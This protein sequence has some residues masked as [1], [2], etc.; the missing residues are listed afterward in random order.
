MTEQ[1][2]EPKLSDFST[3]TFKCWAIL[4]K[5]AY[6]LQMQNIGRIQ[7]IQK[8]QEKLSKNYPGRVI[9]VSSFKLSW[10]RSFK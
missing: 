5:E 3:C 8:K 9:W 6:I 7:L 2:F 10:N 1:E 4:E